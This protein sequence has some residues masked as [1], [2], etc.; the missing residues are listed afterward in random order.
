MRAIA[1]IQLFEDLD[2]R[3]REELRQLRDGTRQ[4]IDAISGRRRLRREQERGEQQV[5]GDGRILQRAPHALPEP[6]SCARGMLHPALPT[7][8]TQPG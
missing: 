5:Q 3:R 4:R 7:G 2:L 8:I 6:P 1:A